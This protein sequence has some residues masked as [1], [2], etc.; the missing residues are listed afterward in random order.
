MGEPGQ[1]FGMG[2]AGLL[3][4]LQSVR[5]HARRLA[6][7]HPSDWDLTRA[8][9]ALA[10]QVDA[11][12]ETV[13]AGPGRAADSFTGLILG[14]FTL[15]LSAIVS[16]S[17]LDT[18]I[19]SDTRAQT[20]TERAIFDNLMSN[21]AGAQR[22]IDQLRTQ[23]DALSATPPEDAAIAAELARLAD[24]M[25]SVDERIGR[26]EGAILADPAK[27]LQ[28]PLLSVEVERLQE[29]S[30]MNFATLREDVDRVQG[31][32]NSSVTALIVGI[33]VAA[34]AAILQLLLSRRERQKEPDNNS[35]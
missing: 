1:R 4:V 21:I 27:A 2:A 33:L 22:E 24:S 7:D 6:D 20:I 28:V 30:Q 16:Y 26:L 29:S 8:V 5:F 19:P 34:A 3:D 31:N 17:S 9:D 35:G 14:T 10:E 23:V 25:S 32:L 15:I 13:T 12:V 11:L 18:N